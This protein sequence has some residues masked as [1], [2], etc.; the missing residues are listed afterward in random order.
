MNYKEFERILSKKRIDR[1]LKACQGNSRKAMTLYRYNLQLTQDVFTIISCFEVALRN[2]ID[3]HLIPILGEE[4]LKNSVQ[5]GGVFTDPKLNKTREIIERAYH[6]LVKNGTYSHSKLLAEMEF[7]IWKYMF[8]PMQ[9]RLTGRTLLK[10]FPNKERSSAEIQYNQSYI[11]NE[12]DKVNTLRNRLAHH[13]PICFYLNE[14]NIDTG[15]ILTEYKKIQCLFAW[16]NID[17]HSMLY[18]LDHV[19]STCNKINKLME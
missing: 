13:E 11:F 10:I 16:M 1:Y 14:P 17:S 9:Y 6:K 15:Y 12:L 7:G 3:V 2:A 4:W 19:L 8:S 5:P 18:G